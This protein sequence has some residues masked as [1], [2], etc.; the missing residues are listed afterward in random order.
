MCTHKIDNLVFIIFGVV[1]FDI[2][3]H[4][5]NCKPDSR[6]PWSHQ[7]NGRVK[8]KNH[9][10]CFICF[11]FVSFTVNPLHSLSSNVG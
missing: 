5:H 10:M 6:K 7:A 1:G 11:M 2:L 3:F 9:L 8:D 4:R